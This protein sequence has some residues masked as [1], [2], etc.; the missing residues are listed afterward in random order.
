MRPFKC[1]VYQHLLSVKKLKKTRFATLNNS[2]LHFIWSIGHLCEKIL[3]H[4]RQLWRGEGCISRLLVHCL[5]SCETLQSSP[6]ECHEAQFFSSSSNMCE[7]CNV[8]CT[9][10]HR[11]TVQHCHL[12]E[13]VYVETQCGLCLER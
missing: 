5:Y 8:N 11:T 6:I 10:L 3:T 4:P 1:F 2:D 7:H 12:V 13:G 9:I